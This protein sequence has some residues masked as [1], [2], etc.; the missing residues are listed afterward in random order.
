MR[1]ASHSELFHLRSSKLQPQG[2]KW[3]LSAR[4]GLLPVP[5]LRILAGQ[6]PHELSEADPM[7]AREHRGE[8]LVVGDR[9]D[10]TPLE[11]VQITQEALHMGDANGHGH[12]ARFNSESPAVPLFPEC[13]S[14]FMRRKIDECM[15]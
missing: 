9:F 2:A 8:V 15:T 10:A 14:C 1:L 6:S 13:H 7:R 3:C 11:V 4:L 5:S 12:R